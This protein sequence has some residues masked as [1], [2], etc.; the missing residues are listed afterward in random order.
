MKLLYM[1]VVLDVNITE[2]TLIYLRFD[3][4]RAMRIA[5][6]SSRLFQ[7]LVGWEVLVTLIILSENKLNRHFIRAICK[8]MERRK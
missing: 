3:L 8:H 4:A 1:Q 7:D 6:I 2:I 5:L